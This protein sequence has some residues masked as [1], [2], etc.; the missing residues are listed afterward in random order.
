MKRLG[1]L[2][3][4][5]VDIIPDKD[6]LESVGEM[7]LSAQFT[8]EVFSPSFN[9]IKPPNT[10]AIS[11]KYLENPSYYDLESNLTPSGRSSPFGDT[12]L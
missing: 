1:V 5:K 9:F 6:L 12:C 4:P 7:K 3:L 2:K 10:P 8:K 11:E